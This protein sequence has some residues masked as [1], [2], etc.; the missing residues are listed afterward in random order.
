M[1]ARSPDDAEGPSPTFI[2]QLSQNRQ[3][4]RFNLKNTGATTESLGIG[5]FGCTKRCPARAF[6]AVLP[7]VEPYCP[8]SEDRG[9]STMAK[10]GTA[11][12]ENFTVYSSRL[13]VRNAEG[14]LTLSFGEVFVVR[15]L[16]NFIVDDEAGEVALMIF[17]SSSGTCSLKVAET[18]APLTA[19]AI[20]IAV[21]VGEK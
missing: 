1:I 6:R 7:K 15:S 8:D 17:R 12:P 13:P 20:A 5:F 16:K 14:K 18:M 10:M 3:L 21:V 11:D 19:F 9:L 4:T 2:A